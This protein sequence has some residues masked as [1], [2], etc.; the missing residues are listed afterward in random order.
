[1]DR[2]WLKARKSLLKNVKEE[3]GRRLGKM[4]ADLTNYEREARLLAR[5]R[6]RISS[7][8][9]IMAEVESA[10]I[11]YG[12]DFHAHGPA[13][14]THFKILRHLAPE[15]PVVLALECFEPRAQKYLDLYLAGRIDAEKLK[16]RVKWD[17][18]WGFPYENYKAL[19]ELAKKRGWRV[20]AIG[21]EAKRTE[22][23]GGLQRQD[24]VTA[25]ALRAIMLN[26]PHALIY[27]VSESFIF[28]ICQSWL[29]GSLNQSGEWR[30]SF[31]KWRSI[32]IRS[33]STFNWRE[34]VWST[35]WMSFVTTR[36]VQ[37]RDRHDFVY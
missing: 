18:R 19:L 13:Q 12:G 7:K 35:R 9:E 29:E 23:Q 17:E 37:A 31:E 1:M 14:R 6:Y 16:M 10:D 2:E 3:V 33:P 27:V 11:V 34:R 26:S 21:L 15:R 8:S 20:Q 22:G 4:P 24:V 25:K 28:L 36:L 5:G 32:S 30:G